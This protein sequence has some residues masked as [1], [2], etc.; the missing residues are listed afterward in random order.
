MP[1]QTNYTTLS[2]ESNQY[3]AGTSCLRLG[4]G[5]P[6]LQISRNFATQVNV[7]RGGVHTLSSPLTGDQ[8][9]YFKGEFFSQELL[10]SWTF[11][12]PCS[13][14]RDI[15]S[16]D[17]MWASAEGRCRM[18]WKRRP[19]SLIPG[20][21]PPYRWA[22]AVLTAPIAG[23]GLGWEAQCLQLEPSHSHGMVVAV[24]D[25]APIPWSCTWSGGEC[26]SLLWI[27]S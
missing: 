17:V 6:E 23:L 3:R 15:S 16:A 9:S 12:P 8:K 19:Y 18:R 20:P 5:I 21:D 10:G 4:T 2:L 24:G 26:D 11:A 7:V 22:R 1:D 13:H 27:L 25:V 14:G